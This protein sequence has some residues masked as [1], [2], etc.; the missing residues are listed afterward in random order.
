MLQ[1][2]RTN[3]RNAQ[4]QSTR[5]G[6]SRQLLQLIAG[7]RAI[8]GTISLLLDDQERDFLEYRRRDPY[9]AIL[10][11]LWCPSHATTPKKPD[12]I[13]LKELTKRVNV[14]L[15]S[16][17]ET[18]TLAEEN[19]GW[20]LRH[21]GLPRRQRNGNGMFISFSADVGRQIHQLVRNYKLKLPEFKNCPRCEKRFRP[22]KVV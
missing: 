4:K 22:V 15:R 14:M 5:G 3:S 18:L 2:A 21:L 6:I 17:G 16:R 9:A 11:C 13:S 19:V 20:K 1:V 10:E 7:E 12:T 8:R